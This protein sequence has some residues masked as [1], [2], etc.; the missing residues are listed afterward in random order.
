MF[1]V[2]QD[3]LEA[4]FEA[5]E[6]QDEEVAQLREEM[7]LLKSRMDA[8]TIVGARPVLSG[9]TGQKSAFVESYL[10]KGLETGWR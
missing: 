5:L 8:Q 9:G 6:R 10:R 3:V 1:E 4:S 7:A 2:K